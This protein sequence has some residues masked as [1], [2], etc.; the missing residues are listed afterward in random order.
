MVSDFNQVG[1]WLLSVAGKLWA[2]FGTWNFLGFAIICF[3]ILKKVV[4]LFRVLINS[5]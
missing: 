2:A 4:R 5:I 1:A 3:P